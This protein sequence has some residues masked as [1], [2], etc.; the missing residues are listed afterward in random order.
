LGNRF[1]HGA[2][3]F[4]RWHDIARVY[5]KQVHILLDPLCRKAIQRALNVVFL[6]ANHPANP[7]D[8]VV[9]AFERGPK[10][11]NTDLRIIEIRMP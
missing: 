8:E 11:T 3:V 9:Q 1:G 4:R 6:I 2:G 7:H 10:I 5:R